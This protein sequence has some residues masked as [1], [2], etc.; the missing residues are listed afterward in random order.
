MAATFDNP[1]GI[2]EQALL[3]RERRAEL[4]AQNLANADTPS[5]KARDLDFRAA[6]AAAD[7]QGRAATLRVTQARHLRAGAGGETGEPLYRVPSQPSI[8]GNTVE[9]ET[10]RSA[11]LDNS[12]RYQ[13]SLQFLERRLRGL[14]TALRGE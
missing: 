6:L 11:F 1:F 4:L 3:L 12:I 13:A 14:L 2:H 7:G 9:P 8:D 10:E 5:Y